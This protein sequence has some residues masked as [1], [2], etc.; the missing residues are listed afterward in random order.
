[1]HSVWINGVQVLDCGCSTLLDEAK[2]LADARQAGRAVV[3]RT[4][5]PNR[6]AWPVS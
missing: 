1:V 2:V 4:G 6:T 3:A 5:L